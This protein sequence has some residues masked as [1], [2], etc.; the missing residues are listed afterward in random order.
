MIIFVI[1]IFRIAIYEAKRDTLVGLHRYRP[2]ALPIAFEFMQP[3]SRNIHIL[4]RTRL[5]QLRKH[6]PHPTGVAWL[7]AGLTTC[8]KK[9]LQ[10]FMRKTLDHSP[11]VTYQFSIRN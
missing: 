9:T 5:M 3:Q 8:E 11:I 6:Q 10:A 2:S 7:N 4:D 1:D